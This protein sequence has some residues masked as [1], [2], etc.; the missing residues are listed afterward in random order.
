M[1]KILVGKITGVFGIKGELKVL[2]DFEMPEKVFKM[3]NK[4]LI[5]EEEHIITNI[6]FHNN[7][8]LMEIDNLKDINLVNKYRESNVYF[9]Y[10]NM[11]LSADEYLLADLLNIDVYNEE[12]LIGKVTEVIDSKQN[13]LIKINNTFYIPLKSSFIKNINMTEKKIICQN[14]EEL[15]K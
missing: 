6:R 9:N 7:K 5:N 10:A 2:S 12:Q 13:P 8:Y 11:E 14:I 1:K 4:I 3:N 15:I